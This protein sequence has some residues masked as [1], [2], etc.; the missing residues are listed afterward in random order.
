MRTKL[1]D[2]GWMGNHVLYIYTVLVYHDILRIQVRPKKGNT[3]RIL[4]WGWD[5]NPKHPIL[6]M[7]LDS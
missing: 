4:L 1:N 5:W 6:G 7:D 2:F 3:P